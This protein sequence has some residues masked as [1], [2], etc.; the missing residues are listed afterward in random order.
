MNPRLCFPLEN[1]KKKGLRMYVVKRDGRR[2][3]V[4]F[5]KITARVKKLSYGLDARFCDPVS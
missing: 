3:P 4:A 1:A 5:D 2:M